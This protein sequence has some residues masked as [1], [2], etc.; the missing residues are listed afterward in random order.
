MRAKVRDM[1][2][3]TVVTGWD[4]PFVFNDEM[5]KLAGTV[6]D[7]DNVALPCGNDFYIEIGKDAWSGGWTYHKSW[8]DFD[9]VPQAPIDQ[10]RAVLKTLEWCDTVRNEKHELVPGCYICEMP[11]SGGKHAPDCALDKALNI[12]S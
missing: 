1:P 7:V 10:L 6:I 8:L 2:V 5:S 3:G 4:V 12:G 9:N 11:Q